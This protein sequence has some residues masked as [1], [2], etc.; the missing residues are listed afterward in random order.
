M[1]RRTLLWPL[2]IGIFFS[3][4][5]ASDNQEEHMEEDH[6]EEEIALTVT[7]AENIGI[8]YGKIEEKNLKSTV[9]LIGRI[10][11]PSTGKIVVSSKMDGQISNV[12]IIEGQKIKKGQKVFTIENLELLDMNEEWLSLNARLT[13]LE[14]EIN[15]QKELADESISPLKNYE[16]LVVERDQAKFR[17]QAIEKK[18]KAVGKIPT[19]DGSFTPVFVISASNTGILQKMMSFRGS[20]IN[21]GEELAHII[22]NSHLHLHLSAY[23]SD[24]NKLEVGQDILFTVQSEPEK[25]HAAHIKWIDA[26]INED[27]NSY[28]VHAEI[29]ENYASIAVGEFVE[30]RIIDQDQTV[31]ALPQSAVVQDRGLNYIFIKEEEHEEEGHEPE[32]HFKKINIKT[33]ASDLGFIEVMPIDPI[34][35][36]MEVVIEGAFFLMAQ[37]KKDEGGGGHDH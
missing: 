5:S 31:F 12:H 15:R 30:A 14:K 25:L 7:Q 28:Q 36:S 6:H 17:M 33:G 16:S 23:S 1:N 35:A 29:D 20:F 26:F 2:F 37:S 10:E 4:N 3:C 34:D 27:N 21:R 18:M 8:A 19:G 13:F 9:K 32:I 22:D 24:V 11:L